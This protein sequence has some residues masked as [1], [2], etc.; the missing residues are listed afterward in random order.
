MFIGCSVGFLLMKSKTQPDFFDDAPKEVRYIFGIK[1]TADVDSLNFNSSKKNNVATFETA[2]N[3]DDFPNSFIGFLL[4][5]LAVSFVLLTM[6]VGY[7]MILGMSFKE[8]I[9]VFKD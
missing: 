5:I 7:R 3:T 2:N 8:S 1:D 9:N 4:K 6:V